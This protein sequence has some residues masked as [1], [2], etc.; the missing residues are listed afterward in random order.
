MSALWTATGRD[1]EPGD[2]ATVLRVVPFWRA[3][4]G[5]PAI[6]LPTLLVITAMGLLVLL[7]A[8]ANIAGLVLVRG[9]SRQGEIAVRLALGATRAR[10]VRLLA[11]ENLV[12]ALPGAVLG[13]LV[14][15]RGIP[16][17]VTYAQALAAPQRVFFNV[18]VDGIVLAFA[19]IVALLCALAFGLA[20][21]LRSSRVDLA[22]VVND[23]SPRGAARG[24]MRA[25][26]VVAQVAVSLLLLV[27]AGLVTRSLEAA[28][29]TNP[30][31][32]GH[33][34]AAILVDVKQTGRDET[35]AAPSTA[36]SSTD[37]RADAGIDI[38]SLA[39]FDPVA[40]LVTPARHFDVEGY[41]PQRDEDLAYLWNTVG[42]D[43][44]RT[45]R[46]GVD[47]GRQ[48]DDRDDERAAPVAMV[49]ATFARNSGAARPRRLAAGSAWR[50]ASGARSSAWRPTSSTCASTSGRGRTSTCPFCSPTARA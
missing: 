49:N 8:C 1:R 18:D 23:V 41:E 5:A 13:V 6:L 31:Y 25:A 28:R 33:D 4:D 26:L 34:V 46:I 40:F 12:L 42:P 50:A 14:A 3:P 27:G 30:G 2:V 37:V 45:L 9:F 36:D 48:F 39:A 22:S 29:T 19:V 20:P 16:V 43:Y 47:A 38:T 11:A 32:D 10:V 44:F 15:A 17:L 7:I 21:A 24:R 35:A